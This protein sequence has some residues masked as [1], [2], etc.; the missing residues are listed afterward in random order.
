MFE[1]CLVGAKEGTGKGDWLDWT[2]FI[3]ETRP[4]LLEANK[5]PSACWGLLLIAHET[6]GLR[7][8]LAPLHRAYGGQIHGRGRHGPSGDDRGR[9]IQDQK[10]NPATSPWPHAAM[11][12]KRSPALQYIKQRGSLACLR[13]LF[14][15]HW[16]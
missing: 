11:T 15:Q 10:H 9:L 6:P 13:K 4:P 8:Q 2:K 7:K 1:A 5:T 12:Q 16:A 3:V 14:G